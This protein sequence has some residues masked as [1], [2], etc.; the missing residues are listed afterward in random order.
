MDTELAK[1]IADCGCEGCRK[2]LAW[3]EADKDFPL[4]DRELQAVPA[5]LVPHPPHFD[6]Y[7]SGKLISMGR[8]AHGH[9]FELDLNTG[10]L[11]RATSANERKRIVAYAKRYGAKRASDRHCV[12]Y[13]TVRQWVSRRRSETPQT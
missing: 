9:D 2:Y 5:L 10:K 8:D 11:S 6:W 4:A 13:A 1:R 3:F 12:E 7:Y